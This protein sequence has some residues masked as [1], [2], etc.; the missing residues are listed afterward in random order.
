M[1]YITLLCDGMA[2]VPISELNGKTPMEVAN[3]PNMNSLAKYS[4]IGLARTIPVGMDPGSD[5]ANMSV[6]GYD[7]LKYYSGRSPLEALSMGIEMSSDDVSFRCNLVTLSDEESRY[8]D[9]Y[10]LDNSSNEISTEEA[11]VLIE[12]LKNILPSS[13]YEL[14]NGIC[15][16]HILI[17]RNGELVKLTPPHDILN[18]KV[19]GYMPTH[20]VLKDLMIKSY[21]ILN[22][23]PINLER[24]K[25]GLRPGNSI[26]FWGSGRKPNLPSYESLIGKKG[27]IYSATDLL[28]GIAV[29]TK[30][31][32]IRVKDANGGLDTNYKGIVDASLNTLLKENFDHVYI[33]M[34]APD[35]LSHQGDLNNKILAIELIDRQILLPLVEGLKNAG[36]DF[37]ILIM[38]DHPTPI[39]LRTHTADPVPYMIYDNR[40][41]VSGCSNFTE[42]NAK[43]K[44]VFID[45]GY[46][47]ANGFFR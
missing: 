1:K 12:D 34:E 19:Q 11:K 38:P 33:H 28:N 27:A 24:R 4:E 44:G 18:K 8:E 40:Y 6:L 46:T 16:R 21:G 47:L 20:N 23:H 9:R 42:K 25:K 22:N 45:P 37:R 13:G 31:K 43:D 5:V 35:E 3:K 10:M 36:E 32:N 26:W 39:P 30:M 17:Q 41:N 7:P 14:Y 2:D 29:G 15:Y